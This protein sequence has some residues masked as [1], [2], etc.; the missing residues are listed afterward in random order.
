MKNHKFKYKCKICGWRGRYYKITTEKEFN[1]ECRTFTHKD[2]LC[3]SCGYRGIVE[4]DT[5]AKWLIIIAVIVMC[6]IP[7]AIQYIY[8]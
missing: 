5:T 2:V 7:I 1:K 8:T 4:H 6:F 3:P